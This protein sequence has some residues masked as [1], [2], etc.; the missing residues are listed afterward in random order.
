MFFDTFDFLVNLKF[1]AI[2]GEGGRQP[3]WRENGLHPHDSPNL[4]FGISRPK[5]VTLSDI[6]VT[7]LSLSRLHTHTLM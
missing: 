1:R 3:A 6:F 4:R 5:T 2:K 7:T